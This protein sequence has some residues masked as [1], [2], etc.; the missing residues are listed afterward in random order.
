MKAPL[1][2]ELLS[3]TEPMVYT[4]NAA[5]LAGGKERI[6][7]AE[8]L[9]IR[10]ADIDLFRQYFSGFIFYLELI[11]F[12]V[13][14]QGIV[15]IMAIQSCL[16]FIYTINSDLI[17]SVPDSPVQQIVPKGHC[18]AYLLPAGA[19]SWPIEPGMKKF[20]YFILSAD[21]PQLE[22]AIKAQMENNTEN[23]VYRPC[24]I[25]R[26]MLWQLNKLKD[27]KLKAK[28]ELEAT[29]LNILNK[30]VLAYQDHLASP[31]LLAG[32]TRKQIA[33]EVRDHIIA[34]VDRGIIPTVKQVSAWCCMETAAL[35]RNCLKSFN[36]NIQ[37]LILDAQMK[38]AHDLLKKGL[39]L[40]TISAM[41][42]YTEV[43]NF[44]RRYKKYFGCSP[45]KVKPNIEDFHKK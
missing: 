18:F 3:T 40:K 44:S 16:M 17:F 9:L 1:E 15:K 36:M 38:K 28:A 12:N 13:R 10:S 35:R 34:E 42:G 26:S 22:M 30:L 45:A 32:K 37:E 39:K 31:D 6:A 19:Y 4:D 29:L 27:C 5:H 24:P 2:F 14:K 8:H 21:Y 11:T 23:K 43:S 7:Y 20:V 25:T 41:L 33:F